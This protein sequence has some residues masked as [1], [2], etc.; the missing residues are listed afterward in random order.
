[1]PPL[2]P[3]VL[4]RQQGPALG[5]SDDQVRGQ[6]DA[7]RWQRVTGTVLATHNGPLSADQVRLAVVLTAVSSEK[8][9]ALCA[10]TALE[11]DGLTGWRRP[12]I[13][14]VVPAGRTSA[15]YGRLP[16]VVHVSR[17]FAAGD[18]RHQAALARTSVERSAVDAA[19]WSR[20]PRT[21]LGVLAACVQQR[22]TSA[23]RLRTELLAAGRIRHRRLL[24]AALTD[25]GGGAQ[26]VSEIDFLRFC[27]R[28]GIPKPQQQSVR[29]DA[30]GRRRYLD[31]TF[32]SRT[33]RVVHVEIDGALHLAVASYWDDM[34]RGNDLVLVDT[35]TLRFPS[36]VIHADDPTAVRQ[37][38]AALDR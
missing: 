16:V 6:L 3:E 31:A 29:Q 24:L 12:R 30:A 32:R 27:R 22:L 36:V 9:A 13:H 23:D 28:H 17:R 14:V 18:V 2:L 21:A 5:L 8:A 11:V 35:P 19:C 20:H 10:W 25:I 1:M 15:D 37:L 26:A 4:R 34:S 7:R 33:G 38:C